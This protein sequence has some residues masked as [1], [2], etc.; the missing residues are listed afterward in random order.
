MS[1]GQMAQPTVADPLIGKRL[2]TD[3]G[4]LIIL[5]A[6]GSVGGEINGKAVVGTYS[7]NATEMCSTYSAPDF[8]K[9]KE[10]CSTPVISGSTVVFQRRDGSSS[11]VYNIKG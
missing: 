4:A 9:D 8:L 5:G 3:K 7:A 10:F 1:D 11:P 6:D 2:M